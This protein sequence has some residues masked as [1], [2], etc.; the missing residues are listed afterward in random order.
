MAVPSTSRQPQCESTSRRVNHPETV[1]SVRGSVVE[2]SSCEQWKHIASP[3]A[4]T[5]VIVHTQR[6]VVREPAR[7]RRSGVQRRALGGAGNKRPRRGHGS[8]GQ[9]YGAGLTPLASCSERTSRRD[10]TRHSRSRAGSA[11]SQETSSPTPAAHRRTATAACHVNSMRRLVPRVRQN[12][13]KKCVLIAKS[14]SLSTFHLASACLGAVP[15]GPA[16]VRRAVR[17]CQER[18]AV[19]G[20]ALT[21]NNQ[22]DAPR[23]RSLQLGRSRTLDLGDDPARLR[24][25]WLRRVSQGKGRRDGLAA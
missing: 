10:A 23:R 5:A 11:Q 2:T 22:A 6:K 24:G 12:P 9:T 16:A 21:G 19:T 8:A 17:A 13:K 20:C 14:S 4:V 1:S 7:S 25:P 18:D 15:N 3:S